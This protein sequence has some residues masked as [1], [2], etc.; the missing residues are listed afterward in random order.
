MITQT[1]NELMT[2]VEGDAPMG[3][4]MQNHYWIPFALSSHLLNER[5]PMP[6][7][8]FGGD[9]VALRGED[10]RVRFLDETCRHRGGAVAHFPV[11]EAGGLSWVWQGGG[12]APP[13]P[14]LPFDGTD[15]YQF[16]C[17]C[18]VPCN[19]L[20]GV[21]GTIDSAHVGVLHQ[22]W[23]AEAAKMAEHSNLGLALVQPPTYE[24]E[25]TSYGMRAAALRK[26]ADGGAYVRITEHLMPLV[27]VVPIGR[28]MPR[29]GS[30]FAI[31]PTDDTHHHLF[32]GTFGDTPHSAEPPE[33]T[34]MQDPRYV[35]EDLDYTGLRGDRSNAWGQDRGRMGRG[36][37]SGFWRSLLEEDAVVQTSMGPIVD[38]TRENLSSGDV[39]VV[40]ARRLLL[41]ALD[42]AGSGRLPPGSALSHDDVKLP[43]AS[44]VF[45]GDGE[46][47]EDAA[48]NPLAS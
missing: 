15:L 9:F 14:D 35:P 41:E 8:L 44:E 30:V 3:Q 4:L 18:Q 26:T 33:R 39:A 5:A 11:H 10:G 42:A 19:W 46:R 23:I 40:Q 43:N 16:W 20:Q 36:H 32:F 7:R 28:A 27:T 13:F 48:I 37:F 31:S 47:W 24:T 45:I 21:E 6:V 17:V 12:E 2:R 29:S 1:E 25:A 38:R 34:A 22:T